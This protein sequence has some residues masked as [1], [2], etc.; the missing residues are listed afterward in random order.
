MCRLGQEDAY[1]FSEHKPLGEWHRTVEW[2]LVRGAHF[3]YVWNQGDLD[4]LYDL[5]GDP[6][7]L[8]NLIDDPLHH[9]ELVRLR[10]RLLRWMRETA[11][12]LVEHF[13]GEMEGTK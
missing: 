2:R 5:Q 6:Y 7:E 10:R 13:N 3:K 1:R 11:D 4:E 8:S 12:P 9:E